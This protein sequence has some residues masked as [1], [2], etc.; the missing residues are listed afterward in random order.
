MTTKKTS[1][2]K[3][4]S[5]VEIKVTDRRAVTESELPRINVANM[6]AEGA[7]AEVSKN[8]A[9]HEFLWPMTGRILAEATN[10]KPHVA[11]NGLA[12]SVSPHSM[13]ILKVA[14][15]AGDANKVL[16]LGLKPGM[17]ILASTQTGHYIDIGVK[18]FWL[19]YEYDVIAIIGEEKLSQ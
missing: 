19:L 9:N 14:K 7:D 6:I 3:N 10:I 13:K 2:K 1:K 12:V 5:E 11:E 8:I 18:S 17:H 4:F 15:I 16:G